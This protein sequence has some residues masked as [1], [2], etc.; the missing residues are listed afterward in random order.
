MKK[1]FKNKICL[2]ILALFMFMPLKAS[3]DSNITTH[4]W[5]V[6]VDTNWTTV[7]TAKKGFNCYIEISST[8]RAIKWGANTAGPDI[9]MLGKHGNVIWSEKEAVSGLGKRIF[10]CGS[11]VYTIQAKYPFSGGN[12][13]TVTR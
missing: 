2:L 8:S 10:W 11:D 3:A 13:S 6:E 9:R 7:A 4:T 5:G 1:I 12:V